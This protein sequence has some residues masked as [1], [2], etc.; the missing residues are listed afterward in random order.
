[1]KIETQWNKIIITDEFTFIAYTEPLEI[2]KNAV[3]YRVPF[4]K[5]LT[6]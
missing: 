4:L 6:V 2:L 3:E 1:M 5:I